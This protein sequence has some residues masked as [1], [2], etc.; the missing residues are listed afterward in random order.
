MTLQDFT[1]YQGGS[2]QSG[3]FRASIYVRHADGFGA[4]Q[5]NKLS[6][7]LEMGYHFKTTVYVAGSF[8][9]GNS[10]THKELILFKHDADNHQCIP[11][12]KETTE[13]VFKWFMK[14]C[15][16]RLK[17]MGLPKE[18]LALCDVSLPIQ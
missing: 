12:T 18:A 9:C 8:T 2:I 11:S 16:R 1:K 13:L 4:M 14:E 3:S 15:N 10:S 5:V 17:T 7:A 6:M